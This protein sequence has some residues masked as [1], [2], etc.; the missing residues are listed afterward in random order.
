[1]GK[2]LRGIFGRLIN[3][4]GTVEVHR[5]PMP[6]P[7]PDVWRAAGSP[8]YGRAWPNA[9]ADIPREPGAGRSAAM[10]TDASLQTGP[11]PG[12]IARINE[13]R[14]GG[15]SAAGIMASFPYDGNFGYIPHTKIGKLTTGTVPLSRTIADDAWVA[16]VYAGNPV[17][18][19]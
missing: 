6:S 12:R 10:P 7:Q 17:K 14:M 16:A 4:S 18:G 1:M 15:L 13:T 19:G 11:A 3:H 8:G 2:P 5:E 9:S